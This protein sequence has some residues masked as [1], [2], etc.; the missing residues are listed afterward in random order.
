M[1]RMMIGL[2]LQVIFYYSVSFSALSWNCTRDRGTGSSERQECP[3]NYETNR[4]FN[5]NRI[6]NC[7]T[8][9]VFLCKKSK[10]LYYSAPGWLGSED[11]VYEQITQIQNCG[12]WDTDTH[13]QVFRSHFTE[14]L[15]HFLFESHLFD[16]VDTKKNTFS[17]QPVFPHCLLSCLPNLAF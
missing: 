16:A 3:S 12:L 14:Q 6:F 13:T 2:Q 7:G 17:S 5:L 9:S 4:I 15:E 10:L 8:R 11:I 1:I